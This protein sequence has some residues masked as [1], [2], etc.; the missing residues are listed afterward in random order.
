[1]TVQMKEM[2]SFRNRTERNGMGKGK[3]KKEEIKKIKKKRK[4]QKR[5]EKKKESFENTTFHS[6]L[7]NN[8]HQMICKNLIVKSD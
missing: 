4:K 7:V 2:I 3:G 5:G 6:Y 8:V 1:M